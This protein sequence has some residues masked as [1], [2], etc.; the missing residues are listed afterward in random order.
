MPREWKSGDY[1]RLS[2]PQYGWGLKVLNKLQGQN[3]RGDEHILDAG[4]GSGRVTAELL[5]A[6]P[7][8]KVTAV[9][10]SENMVTE[11][12]KTLAPFG[13]RVVVERIDLLD[14]AIEQTVDVIFS[15]AVFHWIK[16]QDRLFANLFRALRRGGLLLAQC[17][18][19][20]NLKRLRKRADQVRSLPDFVPFFA[21][22]EAVW[23]YPGPELAAERLQRAGFVGVRTALEEAPAT[24]ADETTFRAFC[25]TI[26]LSPYVQLLPEELQDRFLDPIVIE[27]AKDNPPFTLDYWRLNMQARR[28][29][30]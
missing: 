24:L 2:D 3:L 16:D 22:W 14:L 11:A 21:N 25:A 6:F 13:V 7:K 20:P 15:T 23:E 17:G 28:A 19:G 30:N 29:G 5:R 8:A 1:H 9:D 27:A 26:T 4:C 12:R 10:A 18:G